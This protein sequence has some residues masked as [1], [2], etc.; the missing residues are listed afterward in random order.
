MGLTL[1]SKSCYR[2]NVKVCTHLTMCLNWLQFLILNPHTYSETWQ[3]PMSL[4]QFTGWNSNPCM[5]EMYLGIREDV[6]K[7]LP[8]T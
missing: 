1:Q 4:S 7:L 5:Q 2:P 6:G 8:I 3:P